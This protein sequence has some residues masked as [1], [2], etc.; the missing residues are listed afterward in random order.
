MV[1]PAVSDI[2]RKQ[3]ALVY[4]YTTVPILPDIQHGALTALSGTEW[5]LS[6]FAVDST[7]SALAD[8]F[9]D[10]LEQQRPAG[11]I[12]PP[13][14]SEIRLLTRLARQ[15]GCEPIC[16]GVLPQGDTG[17]FV[18][19]DDRRAAA[20]TI[21][22]LIS[23]GHERIGM[24]AGPEDSRLAQERELGYLDA[25][26]DHDL[27]RGPSLIVNGDNTFISGFTSG[28]LLLEVSPR[29]TAIF[30][31]ND[32]MAAGVLQ[33]AARAGIPVP[34]ALTVVGFEDTALAA[35]LCPQLASVHVPLAEMA[36][37]AALLLIAQ[38]GAEN[39]PSEFPA[40]LV[41]RASAGPCPASPGPA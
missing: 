33:A 1:E 32:E 4:D 28:R 39:L 30:A 25:I 22:W 34:E 18:A 17:R 8:E 19:S 31:A 20:A 16:L 12:L 7:G 3:I 6:V 37:F 11:I 21:A 2:P 40:Q 15:F 9:T 14:L 13:P 5:G 35:R 36:Q 23:L 27:D 38:H 24:I 29:P 41:K 26:A 10:F